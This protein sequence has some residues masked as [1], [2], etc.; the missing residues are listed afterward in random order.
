M[1]LFI[2]LFDELSEIAKDAGVLKIGIATSETLKNGPPSTDL[3]YHL[4]NAKS[5]IVFSLPLDRQVIRR[6]LSKDN[7]NARSDHEIDN[8]GTIIKCYKLASKIARY[9]K[10]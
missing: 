3:T 7:I 6:Y 9:L 8:F 5:A 1:W 10:S 2:S 4:P